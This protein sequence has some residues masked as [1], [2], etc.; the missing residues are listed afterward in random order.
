[1]AGILILAMLPLGLL[2]LALSLFPRPFAPAV[3]LSLV[4]GG[5]LLS[6]I[7]LVLLGLGWSRVCV[8]PAAAARSRR[9]RTRLVALDALLATERVTEERARHLE[10][11]LHLLA[12]GEA[13]GDGLERASR[14]SRF[15]ALTVPVP[16]A[17]LMVIVLP[18]SGLSAAGLLGFV[19]LPLWIALA[20]TSVAFDVASR[21]ARARFMCELERSWHAGLA[22]R[23]LP[24]LAVAW[25]RPA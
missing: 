13:P 8:G 6:G 5:S 24:A 16:T 3:A 10:G 17:A 7:G 23:S 22:E 20:V 21:C 18:G 2:L 1:M 4:V 12:A 9:A 14:V 15:V 11:A 19:L 25:A